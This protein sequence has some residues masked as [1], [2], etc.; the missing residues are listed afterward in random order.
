MLSVLL[1]FFSAMVN[2]S[3]TAHGQI[4]DLTALSGKGDAT[5]EI[6]AA[7]DNGLATGRDV[8]IPA[9]RYSINTD[10]GLKLHSGTHLKLDENT[11][12]IASPSRR[13]MYS[14]ISAVD[15]NDAS[16]S[17][18]TIIG[19]RDSHIG[20]DGQ[21]GMGISIR[22]SSNVSISD[23]KIKKCW[24]DGV[25]IGSSVQ[26]GVKRPSVNI[27]ISSISSMYNR[28]QGLS[29]TGAK[30]VKIINSTFSYTGGHDP[31]SGID[32]EPNAGDIVDDV[33]IKDCVAKG[34]AGSGVIASR[35]SRGVTITGCIIEDNNRYGA[36][37]F[38]TAGASIDN[39][40]IKGNKKY[41]IYADKYSSHVSL[42]KNTLT[43]P[44]ESNKLLRKGGVM[45]DKSSVH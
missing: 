4:N 40:K 8:I 31:E 12:L 28:R 26:N 3:D 37:L 35:R 19:D 13:G 44:D 20:N 41:D 25:Y 17:G 14:I 27:T 9:G 24:G 33:T 1:L 6:Q 36:L 43:P 21:W 38:G 34:N 22:G 45:I 10:V 15:I 11:F 7:I 5:S 23:I 29:V 39:N 42:G 2:G 30:G 16:V 32:L 18:G